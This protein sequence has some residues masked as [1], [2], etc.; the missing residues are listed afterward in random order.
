MALAQGDRINL[1][2]FLASH[3]ARQTQSDAQAEVEEVVVQFTTFRLGREIYGLTLS[4]LREI[5]AMM[6]ITA[7]PGTPGFFLGVINLRGTVFPVLDPRTLL[8]LE[9]TPPTHQSRVIIAEWEGV[10]FGLLVDV[11]LGIDQVGPD[12]I[13]PPLSTLNR[14]DA[15]Y[16]KGGVRG[17]EG[18]IALLNVEQLYLA[19]E[20]VAPGLGERR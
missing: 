9:V 19:R 16:V 6:P 7:V 5:L 1:E 4:D 11:V 8:G 15:E 12:E 17:D 14:Q 20:Q 13:E 18:L 10:P 2:R 3:Q